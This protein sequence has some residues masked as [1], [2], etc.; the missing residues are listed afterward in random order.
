M[1]ARAT[2]DAGDGTFEAVVST[3]NVEYDVGWSWTEQILPG[4]FADSIAAHPTIPIF[5]NHNWDGGPI[6]RA[7]PTEGATSL[8]VA[9]QLYLGQGD[10]VGRVYQAMLD[11]ALEEWSIGFWA[12]EITWDKADPD[13][14]SIAKGDLVEASVCMRGANPET[15]T[16]EPA[17]RAQVYIAGDEKAREREVMRV[18]SVVEDLGGPP[19]RRRSS[20][21]DCSAC[22][23][24]A[25]L[26][27]DTADGDNTGACTSPGCDCSEMD[28]DD[29][30]TDSAAAERRSRQWS[31][32][33][34]GWP[35]DG[36]R[37]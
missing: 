21:A 11:E 1:K 26:H 4:C 13:L 27:N 3:Y 33:A 35:R 15:G 6:G 28:G 24:P 14:D 19:P 22:D 37:L 34:R 36:L 29:V 10:L 25:D 9:G 23:H 32:L 20:A 17:A 5:Y 8:S 2:P 31:L 30:T 18:R 7:A 16:T 12:E